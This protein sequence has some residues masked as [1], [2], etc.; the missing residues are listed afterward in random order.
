[1]LSTRCRS[2]GGFTLIELLVVVAIVG[3]LASIAAGRFSSARE[4]AFVSA[5][6]S[7]LHSLAIAEESYY[8]NSG[9]YAA[10]FSALGDM[11]MASA[12]VAM[13]IN[14]ATNA[15]WSA[16]A[17]HTSTAIR[18]YLFIEGAAPIGSA[19]TVGNSSCS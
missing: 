2:E 17:T 11:F 5:M 15:G 12:G 8:Y 7:D 16:T 14:E 9:T 19:S 10:D 6:K 1:M 3:L 4:K 13:T 18:C